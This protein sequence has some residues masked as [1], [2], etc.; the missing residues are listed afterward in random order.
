V[1][2]NICDYS[3]KIGKDKYNRRDEDYSS[4]PLFFGLTKTP[5]SSNPFSNL[6]K[7]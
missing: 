7:G 1:K 4:L 3:K 2:N 6:E 5:L